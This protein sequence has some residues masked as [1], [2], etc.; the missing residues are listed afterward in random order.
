MSDIKYEHHGPVALIIIDRADRMNSL[1][2]A[3]NDALVEAWRQFRRQSIL[4]RRGSQDLHHGLCNPSRSRIQAALHRRPWFRRHYPDFE[5]LKA[6]RCRDQWLCD[7]GRIRARIS[8]RYQI[9]L[10]KRRIRVAGLSNG[11]FMPV[12]EA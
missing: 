9:L 8:L 12:T 11:V 10:A 4:C 2:F 5:Y 7:F 3:A 6:Y 1:D